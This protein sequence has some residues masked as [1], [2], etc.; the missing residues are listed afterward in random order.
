MGNCLSFLSV[1]GVR[2]AP[3]PV[4]DDDLAPP[5]P[6]LG[7]ALP[8]W[9]ARAQT[10]KRLS[11]S[12]PYADQV[13]RERILNAFGRTRSKELAEGATVETRRATDRHFKR[14][15]EEHEHQLRVERGQIREPIPDSE[16]RPLEELDSPQT[17][18]PSWLEVD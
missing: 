15:M 12:E 5:R 2:R 3:P 8:W 4:A 9:W 1:T 17:P 6:K 18:D 16:L 11:Y 7:P 13:R 14:V 10:L